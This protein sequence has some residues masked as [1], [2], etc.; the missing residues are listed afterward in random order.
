MAK[1]EKRIK[2]MRRAEK[3]FYRSQKFHACKKYLL[4]KICTNVLR[5]V[6]AFDVLPQTR[7][8][9]GV[10]FV[11]NGLGCVFHPGTMIDSGCKIYQNVTL[12]GN[13][14]IIDGVDTNHGAP[15]LEENVTVYAGACIL[16][17]IV[18]GK[19]SIIGAN[20]VLTKNV[21]AYSIVYGNPAVIKKQLQGME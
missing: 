5:A 17:P 2:E 20:S 8:N 6:Y 3:W 18:I 21:P 4:A 12:G 11:H 10:E 19:G 16:G 15:V 1:R 13:S 9:K 14:K 7:I